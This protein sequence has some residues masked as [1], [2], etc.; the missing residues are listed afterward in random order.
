MRL[1]KLWVNKDGESHTWEQ[2][3][4]TTCRCYIPYILSKC[5]DR[6]QDESSLA[7]ALVTHS[8]QEN[9]F[10]L[11]TCETAPQTGP[12]QEIF[13]TA[14]TFGGVVTA[15]SPDDTLIWPQQLLLFRLGSTINTQRS[16]AALHRDSA[17]SICH[18]HTWTLLLTI[19][20]SGFQLRFS[21]KCTWL[22][23]LWICAF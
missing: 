8:P 9:T 15:P 22:Y 4:L 20:N 14:V 23:F 21:F 17:P 12:W 6:L 13:L 18:N 2:Q 19:T 7:H 5:G 10:T 3:L 11:G 1:N 16:L